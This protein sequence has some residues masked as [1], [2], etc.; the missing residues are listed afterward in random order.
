VDGGDEV[1]LTGA[2]GDDPTDATEPDGTLEA[3]VAHGLIGSLSVATGSAS[4]LL[5]A[6][7]R[8]DAATEQWLVDSIQEQ[9]TLVIEGMKSILEAAT[10]GFLDAATNVVLAA[11][12]LAEV[13]SERRGPLLEAL[14]RASE[15]LRGILGSLVRGLPPEVVELLDELSAGH[16]SPEAVP[17]LPPA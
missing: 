14:L 13:P 2:S 4:M 3:I 15:V 12:L 10:M 9:A 6:S 1:D 11:G 16:P 5:N 7:G 17:P 8:F